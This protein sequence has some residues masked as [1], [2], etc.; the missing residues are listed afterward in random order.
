MEQHRIDVVVRLIELDGAVIQ[1]PNGTQGLEPL[2]LIVEAPGAYQVMAEFAL[3]LPAGIKPRCRTKRRQREI[4]R[5]AFHHGRQ[6]RLAGCAL[7]GEVLQSEAFA[8]L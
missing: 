8:S 1:V 3:V 5:T 6:V 4:S 2:S 7:C